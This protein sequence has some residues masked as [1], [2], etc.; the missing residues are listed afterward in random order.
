MFSDI[1]KAISYIES[2]RTKRTFA[3]FKEI[4]EKYHFNVHQKNMI[5]IAGTN[6]KGSTVNFIKEILMH[7]GYTVGTFTSPY[8]VVH[9]DRICINGQMISDND[10][11]KIIND[12]EPIIEKECL[13]MFEI[14]VLIMLRYFDKED[15]DYR[16]IE[17][18]IGGLEDKTNVIDSVCSVITNI[19]YDHQFMLGATLTEIAKHKAGIIKFKRPC[20]TGETNLELLNIFNR[21]CKDN[22]SEFYCCKL[23]DNK[24]QNSFKYL[25]ND[26]YLYN[27]ATYQKKNALLAITVCDYLIDLDNRLVQ[28]A[29]DNFMWP[30]RFEKFG[31]IYLD[32]AHN[33]DGILA[34]KQTI[35]D[36]K[37]D[38]VVIVFSALN[39]KDI[40][41][42]LSILDD[43]LLVKVSFEDE[44][45]LMTDPDYKSVLDKLSRQHK[46]VIVTGSLH[47]IS[48]VRKYILEN[49]Y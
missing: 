22:Q 14:D 12:L 42:M 24:N 17:T 25:N 31:N 4:V 3:E 41:K 5:H 8:M 40:D 23:L 43:Y 20:F 39:D 48:D 1:N 15:L 30:G 19:G 6:G 33:I 28:Q 44:R 32:G 11:L 36:L 26:F 38:D 37:L 35:I 27:K 9:N 2:K 18:G 10:L 46:N 29:L 45:S 13:S 49:K 7:H 47:F 34:L 21:I 16:I